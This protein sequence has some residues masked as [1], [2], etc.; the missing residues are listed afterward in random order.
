[1]VITIG[2]VFDVSVPFAT[3][4]VAVNVPLGFNVPE[5]LP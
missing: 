5:S 3:E 2:F 4:P 1:M